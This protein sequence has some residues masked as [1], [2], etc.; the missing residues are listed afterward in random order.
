MPLVVRQLV[1]VLRAA[2]GCKCVGVVLAEEVMYELVAVEVVAVVDLL[3][4]ASGDG[5]HL[6]RVAC[7]AAFWLSVWTILIS[8]QSRKWPSRFAVQRMSHGFV[9]GL[10]VVQFSFRD[11]LPELHLFPRR[12]A[13]SLMVKLT[14]RV[15][16]GMCLGSLK[17]L[18]LR[19]CCMRNSWGMLV[20]TLAT[21]ILTTS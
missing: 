2:A 12:G 18:L 1:V 14:Y 17:S 4:S 20:S 21:M 13:V 3:P 19:K 7:Y 11:F 6:M 10:L 9:S 15:R 16:V 8:L 5:I